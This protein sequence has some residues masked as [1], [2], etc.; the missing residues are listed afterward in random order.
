MRKLPVIIVSCAVLALV[1][2]CG[3]SGESAGEQPTLL[4]LATDSGAKGSPA[5]NAM[6]RWA[7]LIETGTDG[8]IEVRV[9]YQNELGG[10]QDLFDL[11]IAND[12]NLTLNWPV[13]SYDPRIALIYTPYMFT[14]WDEALEGLS[15]GRVGCTACCPRSMR[16]SA[17]NSSAPGPKVSMVWQRRVSMRPV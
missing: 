6:D 2:G 17:S 4:K 14:A 3:Q 11:Y 15:P 8:Q 12:V 9:F 10:Q 13:T 1:S 7:E 5:G 16:T